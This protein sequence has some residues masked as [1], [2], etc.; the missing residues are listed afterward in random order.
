[1]RYE[2]WVEDDIDAGGDTLEN[3][4]R[5][6]GA[7]GWQ[8]V[9]TTPVEFQTDTRVNKQTEPWGFYQTSC[10]SMMTMILRREIE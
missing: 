10:V 4:L 3:K 9:T 7:D 8:L 2:Y 5:E 1:M 6:L